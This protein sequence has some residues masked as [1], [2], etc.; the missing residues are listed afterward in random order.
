MKQYTITIEKDKQSGMFV[1]EVIW[2]P[3]CYTQAP[4]IPLLLE[5]INEVVEWRLWL[6]EIK[7]PLIKFQLSENVRAIQL[8]FK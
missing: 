1:G 2:L 5:R 7:R 4:S 3:A 6:I 8:N